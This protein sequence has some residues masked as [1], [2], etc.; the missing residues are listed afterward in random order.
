MLD[1]PA[2]KKL[3]ELGATYDLAPPGPVELA[4]TVRG[5]AEAAG[6]VFETDAATGERLDARL[7][8]DADRPD[9]LPLVQLA[10]SRLFEG[11]ETIGGEIVLPLKVYESL[12]GLKGIVNE[13]GETALASLGETEKAR[14]PHLLRQLAVPA[15]DEDKIGQGAL[16]IRAVSLAEAAPDEA[17]RKLLDALVAAR[18]LTTSGDRGRRAGASRPSAGAGGLERERA[19]LSPRARTST[20]FAPISRKAAANGKPA[21]VAAN[22]CSPVACRWPKPRALSASIARISHPRSSPMCGRRAGAL[23][24]RK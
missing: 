17:A 3:K 2:L 7:L 13:A 9:M 16:T 18:L 24:A 12:G 10:L 21:S 20:A 15:H 22:C 19:P 8:R 11:R 23:I 1:Q 6:L 5:P 4:E 14:L